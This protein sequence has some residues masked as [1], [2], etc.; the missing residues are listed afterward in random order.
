[1]GRWTGFGN[2]VRF[3]LRGLRRAP[4]FS[5][6]AV[7][8]LAVAVAV[9]AAVFSFVRGTLFDPPPYPDSDRVVIAW[10]SNAKNGQVRDVVSGSNYSDLVARTRSLESISAIHGDEVVLMQNGRPV[11][12]NSLEVTVDFLDVVGVPPALGRDFAEEDR[13][14]GSAATA[15]VSHAFWSDQLGADTGA[16]GRPPALGGLTGAERT[17]RLGAQSVTSSVHRSFS[18]QRREAIGSMVS[19]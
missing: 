19:R 14:S 5:A 4:G 1:M 12:L 11:V 10:G 7:G 6:A 13:Y 8:I 18:A 9:N 17:H 15:I 16:L 3:V 2:D